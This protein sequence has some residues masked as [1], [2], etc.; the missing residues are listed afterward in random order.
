[1]KRCIGALLFVVGLAWSLEAQTSSVPPK[2]ASTELDLGGFRT[3]ETAITTRIT[4]AGPRAGQPPYLGI[5]V[6]ARAEGAVVVEHVQ[7][8][9]PA[10]RGGLQAGDVLSKIAGQPI[11][12]LD[13]VRDLLLIRE[14][15]ETIGITVRRGEQVQEVMVKLAALSRPLAV[16][17]KRASLGL[18]LD[19]TGEGEGVRIVTLM[20]EG[21]AEK[22]GLKVGDIL[23]KIDNHDITGSARLADVMFEK[24]PGDSVS[25]LYQRDGKEEK[26]K[27]TLTVDTP[28][29]GKGKG[30]FGGGQSWDTRTMTRW[31]K[32]TYRLALIAIDYPDVKHNPKISVKDWEDSFFSTKS[33]L[34]TSVTGQKVF[35]SVNDYYQEQSFGKLRVTGKVFDYVLVSKKRGDYSQGTGTGTQ[36]RSPLLTEAIDKVLERDGKEA[37]KDFDGIFF[38]YAGDRFKTSRGGL[39]WP[40]RATVSHQGKRWPY[41]I[42]PEGGSKMANISVMC[43]E[44]G[45][46]L[47]LPDLY[48]RPE[49]PG[50]E[51]VGAWCAM[52]NQLGNG[53][54]QHFGA[55]SKEQ[56]NWIAPCVID[57]RVKQKLILR[58]IEDSPK[59]CIK[60][61]VRL[62]GSEYFLL[63]N[64]RKKGF[65]HEL[66]GE[67]LLI[68]RV[69]QNKPMVEE[70]H[71]VEGPAGPRLFQSSVPYPSPSNTAFTPYTTPSSRSQLG[72]GLAVFITNI[73]RLPDGR[74]TFFIGYEYF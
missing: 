70:S 39:Y 65:D 20:P 60:V 12:K 30:G 49:N 14:P 55:W 66:P 27:A 7:A 61:L 15:D 59:E 69:V 1:M 32:D 48:A 68:W 54:P 6:D 24:K 18:R 50:S 26:A 63:E 51:G 13:D 8:G 2:A 22:A 74:I 16:G 40:H 38:L 52:S 42:C 34:K 10:A 41:F 4:K 29:G 36:G 64:R 19:P 44:F 47:G 11:R 25:L 56:L 17:D 5:H 37:L 58:P 72:G 71:G 35:G 57:P 21:P 23:L 46:M 67:G 73:Q 9:S 31:T 33:Y 53:R 45:H 62:D 3:V 28:F 43:H